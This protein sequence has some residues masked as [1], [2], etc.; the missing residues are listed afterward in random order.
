VPVQ[1][2]GKYLEIEFGW[3]KLSSAGTLR[4]VSLG[5]LL[6]GFIS[7]L[8]SAIFDSYVTAFV[9]LGL[10]FWG[11]LFLAITPTKY[12]KLELLTAASSSEA[13]NTE[14]MLNLAE[15]NHKGVY[16]PPKLLRDYLSSLVFV[17]ATDN[18]ALPKREEIPE[19][20]ALGTL[21]GMFLTPPGLAL[22]RLFEEK[23]GKPFTKLNLNQLATELPSLL[24]ELGITKTALITIEAGKVT[25]ETGE[26]IFKDLCLET[27]KFRRTHE[28]IGCAFSSAIACALAKAS[29]KPVTI[30][31]EEHN[32]NN[33]TTTI[34]YQIL[35]E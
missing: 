12:V 21:Q 18:E 25:F 6:L 7:L 32:P 29:G 15:T 34:T 19:E 23:L 4:V 20:K 9:G 35:E 10:A 17:P 30:E 5:I 11:V 3:P 33:E 31:K 2:K 28:T 24:D 1:K 16:L 8:A 22:S 13:A 27:K 26:Y 14:K